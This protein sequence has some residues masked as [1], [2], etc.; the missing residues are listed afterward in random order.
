VIRERDDA[1]YSSPPK[2]ETGVKEEP[3]QPRGWLRFRRP[4]LKVKQ[5]PGVKVK[6]ESAELV[7]KE[8]L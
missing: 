3:Q 4:V 6:K 5:D 2:V 7:K 1:S 8:K